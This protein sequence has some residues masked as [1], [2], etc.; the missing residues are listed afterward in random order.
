MVEGISTSPVVVMVL[1]KENAVAAWR[2]LMGPTN[3]ADA[4]AGTIRALY[5]KSIGENATHGSDS[6]E[7]SKRERTIFFP[8]SCSTC[9]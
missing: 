7:S 9:S 6:L 2:D 8:E 1:E 4:D 5:G 3:P